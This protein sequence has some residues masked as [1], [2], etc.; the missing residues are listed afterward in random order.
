M[1]APLDR[2]PVGVQPQAGKQP[3]AFRKAVIVIAGV[4]RWLDEQGGL[5]VLENPEVAVMLMLL[6]STWWAAVAAPH[7]NPLGKVYVEWWFDRS[8]CDVI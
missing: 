2:E 7:R 5:D 1:R 6:P 3:D 8:S 4:E